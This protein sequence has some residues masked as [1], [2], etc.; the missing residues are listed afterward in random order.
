M[1]I[2]NAYGIDANSLSAPYSLLASLLLIL[3]LTQL[4]LW[5]EKI[6]FSTYS[7]NSNTYKFCIHKVAIAP[8]YGISF[9]GALLFPLALFG[10]HARLLFFNV[11]LLLCIFGIYF[12]YSS[13]RLCHLQKI[14]SVNFYSSAKAISAPQYF[15]ITLLLAYALLASSPPTDADDLDYHS[16]VAIALLN[17]GTWP[18]NPEWFTS[19]L[20]GPGEAL[21]AIGYAIGAIQFGSLLQFCGLICI[22]SILT[23][24]YKK[25]SLPFNY[26][27]G[28]IFLSSP[29]LLWLTST[30][31]PLLLP[32]AM[33]TLALYLITK[34]LDEP[35]NK[36]SNPLIIFSLT[37]FL[38]TLASQ[39][40]FNFLLSGFLVGIVSIYV[41][42]QRK[43]LHTAIP[44]SV[45]ICAANFFPFSI[46]KQIHYGGNWLSNLYTLFPGRWPGYSGFESYL[47]QYEESNFVFPLSLIISTPSQVTNIIGIGVVAW[48]VAI[49]WLFFHRSNL[50]KGTKSIVIASITLVFIGSSLGQHGGRFYL[51]PL[52]WGLMAIA[53]SGNIPTII[54]SRFGLILIYTQGTFTLLGLSACIWALL[55]GSLN[56]DWYQTVMLKKAFQ[57]PEMAAIDNMISGDA[58]FLMDARSIALSPRSSVSTFYWPNYI[59]R[60]THDYLQY[61]DLIKKVGV[62]H[63]QT[64]QDIATSP[65]K[66]CVNPM[67][68]KITQSQNNSRNPLNA[69]APYQVWLYTFDSSK[70]PDCFNPSK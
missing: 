3:G 68:I 69:G 20:A 4:G 42:Y 47:R 16:G 17:Q 41:M 34:L 51:E 43:L 36:S 31:K 62:T 14:Q 57:Y 15:Y 52:A 70:L 56:Q 23:R 38:I 21:I 40:K 6:A 9:V 64:R 25:F 45:F 35:T 54:M 2:N 55:P 10:S 66:D 39:M 49:V 44:I 60:E 11:S 7:Q 59:D 63:F 33:T 48:L 58:V 19:R 27:L 67:P 37:I 22:F 18:F 65:W 29:V 13:I 61:L 5:F 32:I 26:I 28:L 30:S 8:I 12:I 53:S 24:K 1:I 46:W 50:S